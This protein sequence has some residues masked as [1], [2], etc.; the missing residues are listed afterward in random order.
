MLLPR[1]GLLAALLAFACLHCP[2]PE[3]HDLLYEP[4]PLA[5][6]DVKIAADAEGDAKAPAHVSVFLQRGVLSVKGG[7]AHTLEGVATG[8]AGD[9]PPRLELMQDRVA[10][11]QATVGGAPPKGDAKFVLALGAT[12]MSLQVDTGMGEAQ[13]ID[14]GGASVK[15]ARFH[16]ASGHLAIDWSAPN[17]LS[18]GP[19]VL[20]T[21]AGYI[22]VTHLGRSGASSIDVTNVAGFVEPRRGRHGARASLSSGLRPP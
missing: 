10:L 1:H 2:P 16:T 14:L 5:P 3:T 7:G 8:A 18:G 4:V 11:T 22:E 6:H 12:P 17:R 21:E 15:Q 20:A 19:V 9:A 13:A